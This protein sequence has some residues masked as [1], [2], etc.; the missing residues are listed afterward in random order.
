MNNLKKDIKNNSLKNLYLFT[1]EEIFLSEFYTNDIRKRLFG[2]ND[3]GFN[4][5]TVTREKPDIN[6]A[7]DFINSYPFM[8]EKK[9]LIIKESGLLKKATDAEKNFWQKALASVPRY[10]IIIFCENDIDKRNAIYKAITASGCTIEFKY[11]QGHALITWVQN[12]I[13]SKGKSI[14][15]KDAQYLIDACNPGMINIKCEMEKLLCLRKENSPITANDIDRLVTKSLQSKVFEMAEDIARGKRNDAYKKLDSL[16]ALNVK[17][18][19]I[20]PAVFSKFSSYRKI[21]LLSHLSVR[22][23]AVKMNQKDFFVKKDMQSCASMSIEQIEKILFLCKEADFKL[24][25]GMS[26]GWTELMLIIS[27]I[28]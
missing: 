24:K 5:L 14:S 18:P 28:E 13:S 23:I 1:G 9:L 12:F 11:Q 20:L 27:E 3:D 19:E 2:E 7:D 15:S 8:S 17:P 25:N 16:R 4:L 26:D 21:K 6:T 22:E 10:C